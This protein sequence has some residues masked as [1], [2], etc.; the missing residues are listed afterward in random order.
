MMLN[1][2]VSESESPPSAKPLDVDIIVEVSD[3][4]LEQPSSV[5]HVSKDQRIVVE[6]EM[7]MF[8]AS[9]LPKEEESTHIE[10]SNIVLNDH[11]STITAS[12]N[13]FHQHLKPTPY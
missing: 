1:G 12:L 13:Q 7:Q 10:I 9:S 8:S 4:R 2:S 11:S 3:S 5:A 6:N